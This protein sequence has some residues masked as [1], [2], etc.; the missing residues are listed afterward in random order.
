LA[1]PAEAGE[2]TFTPLLLDGDP[3]PGVGLVTSID[4]I[5][6]NNAGDWLVEADTDHPDTEADGVLIRN[7]ILL[8]REGDALSMPRGASLDS[9]DS[10][11]L[12]NQ[13]ESG[14]NFFLDGTQ[15]T[16]DDSG[17]YFGTTLVVQ[18][19]D[20]VMA[21][22]FSPGTLYLGFFDVK[23]NDQGALLS[24]LSIE[25]PAIPTTVDRALLRFPGGAGPG[26]AI[27]KEGDLLSGQTDVIADLGTGPHQ[28]A[29]NAA[30]GI[31]IFVDLAGATATDGAIYL[32]NGSP[33]LLAQ[34]GSPSPVTGRNWL[35]LSAPALDL[36]GS[37]GY[38]HTGQLDGDAATNALIVRNGAV[39]RQEGDA[40]PGLEKTGFAI[41]SFGTGPLEINDRGGVLW[42]ADW[43]DPDTEADTGL[44][45][46]DV[47]LL[48]E[49]VSVL[50]GSIV[51]IIR[52]VEDGYHMSDDGSLIVVEVVLLD[53][54]EGAFL[55]DVGG[56][57]PADVDGNGSV[58]VQD[59]VNVVLAWGD[60]PRPPAPCPE[61]VDGDGAVGVGDLVSVVLAW[62][63]C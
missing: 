24:V 34:E 10:I 41:T 15:G 7:G 26:E 47:M 61:D 50:E 28:S 56:T 31:L 32:I 38:V 4:N 16:S 18:E 45:L 54:R 30:G 51:D 52:G 8:L 40:P 42:Y 39:F 21:P 5:A 43:N 53:G 14:W 37:G 3:V 49:G 29:F 11:V 35:T 12:N 27:L 46:D 13:G 17:I 19:S 1:F 57:C 59:M 48:Q 22:G 2:I 55:I 36:N 25:D 58:G 20:E 6:V 33:V 60:C 23:I 9:F 62:G 63:D 44:Y